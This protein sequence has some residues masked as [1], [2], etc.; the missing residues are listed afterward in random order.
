MKA[1]IV[2]DSRI[3]RARSNVFSGIHG[4]PTISLDLAASSQ[5]QT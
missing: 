5:L 2:R 1:A 3:E 4:A